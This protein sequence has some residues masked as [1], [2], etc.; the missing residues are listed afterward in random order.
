MRYLSLAEV[1]ELHRMIIEQTG[2]SSGLRDNI[3]IPDGVKDVKTSVN[4]TTS[5]GETPFR[6][7]AVAATAGLQAAVF[8]KTR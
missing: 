8:G 5:G 7:T 4:L 2:R 6:W 3:V 1:L